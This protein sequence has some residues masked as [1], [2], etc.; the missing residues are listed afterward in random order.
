MSQIVYFTDDLLF[1]SQIMDAARRC[2]WTLE[3]VSN[4]DVLNEYLRA[5]DP[6]LLI[7]DLSSRGLAI[8]ELIAGARRLSPE[9]PIVAYGPHVHLDRLAEAEHAGCTEVLSRGS[10]SRSPQEVLQRYLPTPPPH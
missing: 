5:E 7:V 1:S 9:L 6:R 3:V 4:S 10:F 8:A 2:G